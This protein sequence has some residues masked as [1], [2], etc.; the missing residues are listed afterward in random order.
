MPITRVQ[1]P[2]RGIA[3]NSSSLSITLNSA[4]ASGNVIVAVIGTFASNPP[5]VS[6]ITQQSGSV[7]WT[8]RA[9]SYNSNLYGRRVEIWTGIVSGTV[10]STLNIALS[11]NADP[12]IANVAEYSGLNTSS[13][14]DTIAVTSSSGTTTLTTG[15]TSTTIQADE[16]WVGGIFY[17]TSLSSGGGI[18]SPTNSFT[19]Y[20]G[21]GTG[22]GVTTA[23][24]YLDRI[25]NSIGV[26]YSNATGAS[27]A[28]YSAY[29][30]CI[31]TLKAVTGGG[32][33][34]LNVAG[35][36]EVDGTTTLKNPTHLLG[37][38]PHLTPQQII[39]A[40]WKFNGSTWAPNGLPLPPNRIVFRDP[41]DN[42]NNDMKVNLMAIVSDA[43]GS[44]IDPLLAVDR[45]L[46]V[47]KDIAAGGFV[48]SNQGEFWIGHGRYDKT[49]VPKIVLMHVDSNIYGQSYDTLYLR[50]ADTQLLTN[51]AHL[52]LGNL[53]AHG[54]VLING[55]T[56]ISHP[57]TVYFNVN[58]TNNSNAAINLMR[59]GN[60]QAMFGVNTSNRAYINTSSGIPL[61]LY[62]NSGIYAQN[63]LY[64]DTFL[65]RA[66]NNTGYMGEGSRYWAGIVVNSLYYKSS[67]SFGCDRSLSG[68][69]WV[70]GFKDRVSA[71]KAL[72]DE[73]TRPRYHVLYDTDLE[74]KIVCTCGK[75][76]AMP[77]P[78]HLEDWNSRYTV[79]MSKITHAAGYLTLEQERRIGQ[80]EG[81]VAELKR[82]LEKLSAKKP[83]ASS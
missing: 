46:V 21:V 32:G 80:L 7:T 40:I 18:T 78:E 61:D 34:D 70:P 60:T 72:S 23:L 27:G 52:D 37:T 11:A 1:L 4:P 75:K 82:K 66:G 20:D 65:P 83:G 42:N 55:D 76:V 2:K 31:V 28:T 54:N 13:L 6:S 35:N 22:S 67:V 8:Q 81:E 33:T 48:S 74:D 10:S 56:Q 57:G 62:S 68:Q 53:T 38:I 45:G 12:V 30:G 26:A 3:N 73:L 49:D 79:N 17:V 63:T 59:G 29:A 71:E 77:C 16:L 64:A 24:A 15:T 47:Q 5:A 36:L 43:G 69:E 41:A 58:S 51:P 14:L 25:V 44:W 50:K 19:L 9:N 39:D